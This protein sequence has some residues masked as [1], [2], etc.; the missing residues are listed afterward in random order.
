M[1]EYLTT[2]AAEYNFSETITGDEWLTQNWPEGLLL[3]CPGNS[4]K[5]KD[6][7]HK[8]S[9]EW[10]KGDKTIVLIIKASPQCKY[11]QNLV[12]NQALITTIPNTNKRAKPLIKAVYEK[13][14][15]ITK[16]FTVSFN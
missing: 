2:L 8:V 3:C 6:F 16:S 10:I 15:P 12:L 1:N 11:F 4:K 13:R 14:E 5:Y 9:S 7:I